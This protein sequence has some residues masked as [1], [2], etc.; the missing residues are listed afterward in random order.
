MTGLTETAP[1]AV[2]APT[3]AAERIRALDTI[4]GF[5]LL[6]ILLLNI[7]AYGMHF[8][9]YMDPTVAGGAT[10]INLWIFLAN[11]LLADAKMRGIFALS[12]GAGVVLLTSRLESRGLPAADIHY[13]R[14]LWLLLA[15]IVHAYFLFVGD[16][17]YQYALM[18]LILYPFRKMRPRGLLIIAG[19]VL[20]LLT[21][22]FWAAAEDTKE[23]M[24]KADLAV[25]ARARGYALTS[26]QEETVRDW[27]ES[28][29]LMKPSP[30]ELHRTNEAMAG[31][32]V[33]ALKHRAE[34]V[35]EFHSMPLYFPFH[36]D[37]LLMMLVGMAFLKLG[38]LSADRSYRFYAWMAG[39][40]YAI[41][42]PLT[43]WMESRFLA[44]GFDFIEFG[45]ILI[46]YEPARVAVCF[47][48]LAVLMMVVKAGWLRWMLDPLAAVGR[49]AFSNYV[50]HSVVC[51]ALFSSL[52]WFGQMERYQLY[53]VVAA[54]WVVNLVWS[55]VWLRW[56][57]F[58]PLEWLWRSLTYWKR[59]PMRKLA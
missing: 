11:F 33:S 43:L 2:A 26:D 22:G 37:S 18:G 44:T 12:F 9:A 23:T 46:P 10:G 31:G 54:I 40:G 58:G 29:D 13:R 24:E 15:G 56:F 35:F 47:G 53:Y 51:L 30:L 52:G 36:W 21:L 32:F 14:M 8:G 16:I 4:R 39:A 20:A 59:Q 42:I 1:P 55:P 48:H 50:L 34:Q 5:A 45:F 25:A 7:L 27:N 17:L 57:R 38:V 28:Q 3:G 41:G 49:M 6:G 19:V